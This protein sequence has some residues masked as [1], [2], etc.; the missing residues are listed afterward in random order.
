MHCPTC[1]KV[2]ERVTDS[3]FNSQGNYIRRRRICSCGAKW[4]TREISI[5]DY[6]AAMDR[7]RIHDASNLA[8]ASL[9]L[10]I[11]NVRRIF[12]P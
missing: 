3:R 7:K 6:E 4:T 2:S 9:D 11:I 1:N 12:K 5:D 10:A 8:L